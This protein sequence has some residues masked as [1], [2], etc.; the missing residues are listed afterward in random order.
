M[1]MY[2]L[3]LTHWGRV[4][5]IYVDKLTIIGSDNGLSP[6]QRQ[7]IIWNQCWNIVNRTLGNK[8][9]W[10]LNRNSNIF[11]EENTFENVICEML[12]NSSWPQSVKISLK[13]VHRR[14][15][16]NN[17]ELVQIMTWSRSGNKPLPEIMMV[18]LL[19]YIYICV[20]VSLGLSELNP[21]IQNHN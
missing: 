16:N 11:I 10:N 18:T 19:M 14:P 15:I 12:F 13:L 17:P 1:K 4:T 7:A 6:E 5:H 21:P 9:Q 2:G 20:C 3:W 8:L